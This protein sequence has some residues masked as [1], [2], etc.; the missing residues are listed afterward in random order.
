LSLSKDGRPR[1][2]LVCELIMLGT[3]EANV[4]SNAEGHILLHN[5][6]IN[7]VQVPKG[8]LRNYG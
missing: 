7:D 2:Y 4:L 6:S 1:N 8:F 5:L 3:G